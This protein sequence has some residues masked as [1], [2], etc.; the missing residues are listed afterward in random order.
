MQFDQL[1]D[2][3]QPDADPSLRALYTA[4]DLNEQV[5]NPRQHFRGDADPIIA[6]TQDDFMPFLPQFH[7]D[8]IHPA[9]CTWLHY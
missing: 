8:P 3:G 9:R 6:D 5:E 7:F 2:Q 4:L 1:P